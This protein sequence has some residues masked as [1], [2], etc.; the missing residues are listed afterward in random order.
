MKDLATFIALNRFG[1]GAA[2]GE[3]EGVGDDPRG[4]VAMQIDPHAAPGAS[5]GV[6][7]A[8]PLAEMHRGAR[9]GPEALRSAARRLYR[10][11]FMRE[12]VVRARYA[13]GSERPFAERMALFWSNHFTVSRT[14]AIVGPAIPAYEREAIRPYVF[15]RF[16]DMLKA[17][18][19]HPCMLSYLDNIV[20]IGPQ[21]VVG[22]NQHGPRNP[23][24]R[25]P[26]TAAVPLAYPNEDSR[27]DQRV[28]R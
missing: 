18:C 2:P 7:S 3:A 28:R 6:A 13:I 9:E 14:R 12:V 11:V 26:E 4:W 1:L 8:E 5:G 16:A 27:C 23:A 17:V 25:V 10:S 20:S 15:G 22:Q 19:R 24:R 21:S